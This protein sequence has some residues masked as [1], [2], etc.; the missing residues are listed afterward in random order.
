MRKPREVYKEDIT[1]A[2][3]ESYSISLST[4][5]RKCNGHNLYVDKIYTLSIGDT[6]HDISICYYPDLDFLF[7]SSSIFNEVDNESPDFIDSD[8]IE[9]YQE[10][11]KYI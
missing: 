6:V 1:K 7:I 4:H 3:L 10:L 9:I 8:I 5:I 11:N 2:I